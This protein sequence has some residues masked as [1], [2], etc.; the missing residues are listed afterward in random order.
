[1]K[2]ICFILVTDSTDALYLPLKAW[3]CMNSEELKIYFSKKYDVSVDYLRD[4]EK[5]DYLVVPRP[6]QPFANERNLPIIYVD[7]PLFFKK[8]YEEIARTISA[9]FNNWGKQ[10]GF[11]LNHY[12]SRA[13]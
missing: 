1:M 3:K 5:V 2:K 7:L 12:F 4:K 10:N 8:D 6:F 11:I 9:Y 13:V